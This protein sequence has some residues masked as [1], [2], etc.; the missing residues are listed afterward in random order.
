V[1]GLTD[2]VASWPVHFAKADLVIEAVFEDLAVKH[3]V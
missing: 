2:S 3:T 1:V